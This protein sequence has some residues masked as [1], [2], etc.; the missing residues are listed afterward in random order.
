MTHGGLRAVLSPPFFSFTATPEHLCKPPL[1]QKPPRWSAS[2]PR[3]KPRNFS[4]AWLSPLSQN[5]VT[6][7]TVG[8][9]F[10]RIGVR[11]CGYRASTLREFLREHTSTSDHEGTPLAPEE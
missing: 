2:S 10:I 8:P 3:A 9:P 5:G 1:H 11:K 6:K 4:A 7:D